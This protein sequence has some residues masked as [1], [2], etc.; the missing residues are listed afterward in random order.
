MPVVPAVTDVHVPAS[1]SS[2]VTE[3]VKVFPWMQIGNLLNRSL[4]LSPK[5]ARLFGRRDEL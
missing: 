3:T 1:A 4:L 2:A 5:S